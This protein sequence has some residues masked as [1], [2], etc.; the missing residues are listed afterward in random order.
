MTRQNL[1]VAVGVALVAL[2]VLTLWPDWSDS[3]EVSNLFL[4]VTF[5]VGFTTLLLQH[6]EIE[7]TKDLLER[8]TRAQEEMARAL[9]NAVLSAERQ[10]LI[11]KATIKAIAISGTAM[12][13]RIHADDARKVMREIEKIEADLETK[14][15][16]LQ[17]LRQRAATELGA[18]ALEGSPP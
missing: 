8:T 14:L 5:V 9:E 4:I 6:F 7:D 3:T 2:A 13:G 1:I 12:V 10:A 15:E 11:Q 18:P 16:P 17:P